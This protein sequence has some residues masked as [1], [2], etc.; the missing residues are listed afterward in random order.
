M[1]VTVSTYK[2][3]AGE[4]DAIIALHEDWQKPSATKGPGLPFQGT[5]Q[6]YRGLARV[7]RHHALRESRVRAG[8]R[9]RPEQ[10]AWLSARSEPHGAMPIRTEY[11]ERME[12]I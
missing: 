7:H 1:F 2:A 12:N 9:K 4:E 11:Y 10:E 8:T 3:K 6:E 5:A